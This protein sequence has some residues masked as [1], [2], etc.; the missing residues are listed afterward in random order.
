[1]ASTRPALGKLTAC[2]HLH[3]TVVPQPDACLFR[4][5]S[6]KLVLDIAN[7]EMNP[8]IS[9]IGGRQLLD[10]LDAESR[11]HSVAPCCG[12]AAIVQCLL[13]AVYGLAR[14]VDLS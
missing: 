4:P 10:W 6:N 1:M 8:F 12:L 11:D 9:R 2:P 7:T 3:S 14:M 13:A 5:R